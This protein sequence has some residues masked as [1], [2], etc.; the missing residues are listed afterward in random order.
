M[1]VYIRK[2]AVEKKHWLDNE[3][4]KDGVALCQM[5]P[6][7]TATQTAAYVG[8]RS[9]GVKGAVISFVSFIFPAFLLMMGLSALYMHSHSLPKVVSAFNG[10]QVIVVAIIANATVSYGRISLKKWNDMTI[11][12]IAAVMFVFKINPIIVIPLAA[13]LGLLLYNRQSSQQIVTTKSSTKLPSLVFIISVATFI[14]LGL[15][16]LFLFNRKLFYVTTVMFRVGLFAFGGGF[17]AIPLMFHEIVEAHSWMNNTTFLNGIA[18]GQVTPGPIMITST[19]IGCLLNGL[20]GGVIATISIFLPSILFVVFTVPYFDR[21][22]ASIYFN[23]AIAG[24]LCSFVG[25][26]LSVTIR[27]ALDIPWDIPRVLL[28]ISA[29]AALFLKVDILWVVLIGT[30]IS[31]FVL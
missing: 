20:L 13:I 3:S 19:F 23:K 12:I 18:L 25:L 29:F 26:L 7:A 9:R 1:V 16:L 10:L 4:F 11:A 27:F 2:M 28:T 17:G 30:V 21:L 15:I 24:I 31:V 8:L 5:I 14:L 6:G 22:K